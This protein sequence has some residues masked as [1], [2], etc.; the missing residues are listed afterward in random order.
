MKSI[1]IHNMSSDLAKRIR[2]LAKQQGKSQNAIIKSLL[3][4]AVG[5]ET[6][7]PKKNDLSA[8]AG[9][10]TVSEAKEFE[11]A[12]SDFAEVDAEDWK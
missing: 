8:F 10:W 5:L 6:G 2:L 12:I 1:T 3:S 4:E 11:E 7:K 9:R